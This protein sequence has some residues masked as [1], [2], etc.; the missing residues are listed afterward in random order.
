[1]ES[2]DAKYLLDANVYITAKNTYYAFDLAPQFWEV[3]AKLGTEGRAVS[4]DRVYDELSNGK[5]ALA[6]W[7]QEHSSTF[8]STRDDAHILDAY[9]HLQQWATSQ[10]QFTDAARFEFAEATCADAW[11]VAVA[12][13]KGYKVVSH[14][15][16][17]ETITWK[18]KIPNACK[19]FKVDC[20]N[21]FTMLRE[22]G[23][24]L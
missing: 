19:A 4:I 2:S 18:V 16:Y 11:L 14:E 22:L 13:A 24:K 7:V 8:L 10:S 12:T 5:D 23:I 1:V 20:V 6:Q 9:R 3:L 15:A 21:T 17:S